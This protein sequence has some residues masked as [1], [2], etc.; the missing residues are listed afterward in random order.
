MQRSK[1]KVG[2]TVSFAE[3]VHNNQTV[4]QR[5]FIPHFSMQSV[6]ESLGSGAASIVM[7]SRGLPWCQLYW[8]KITRIARI[9]WYVKWSRGWHPWD[10]RDDQWLLPGYGV[11]GS[12]PV[13]PPSSRTDGWRYCLSEGILRGALQM[14][15][16]WQA[17]RV[18]ILLNG[19]EKG[20]PKIQRRRV[21]II[22]RYEDDN[23]WTYE[24]PP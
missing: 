12:R 13:I 18:S 22:Y 6:L 19:E 7:N 2:N 1:M 24:H 3:L 8:L 15:L 14:I 20:R 17:D 9:L 11:G 10:L 23:L 21:T 4:T 5:E 16:R